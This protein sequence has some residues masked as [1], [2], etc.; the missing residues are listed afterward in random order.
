MAEIMFKFRGSSRALLQMA[1]IVADDTDVYLLLY[2]YYTQSLDIPMKLQS[3][4][5]GRALINVQATVQKLGNIIPELLHAY[6]P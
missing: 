1:H 3:T 4:H 2:H 6:M 5:I